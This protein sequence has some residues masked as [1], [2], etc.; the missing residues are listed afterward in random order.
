[1][2]GGVDECD[3]LVQ[4]F[5]GLEEVRAGQFVDRF[6]RADALAAKKLLHRDMLG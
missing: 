6:D 5:V 2:P 1:M 4:L 3:E